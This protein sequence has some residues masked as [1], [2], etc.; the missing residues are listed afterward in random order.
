V[1]LTVTLLWPPTAGPAQVATDAARLVQPLIG[2]TTATV[3]GALL[4]AVGGGAS[5]LV[6]TVQTASATEP[7]GQYA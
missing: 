5:L 4:G 7:A 3:M 6:A 1:L 2:R